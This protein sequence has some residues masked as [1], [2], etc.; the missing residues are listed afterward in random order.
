[1]SNL[2]IDV[3]C[4]KI[5]GACIEVHKTLGPGLFERIYHQCLCRELT[6]RGI[7]YH[8]E[9]HISLNYKG[10]ELDSV[11]RADLLVEDTV[12]VELKAV[13]EWN[14]IFEAQ[15]I[16]YLRLANKPAGLLINFNVPILKDGIKRLFN[17]Q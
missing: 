5:I 15:L 14:H 10:L 6:L 8:D 11:L 17:G 4:G 3:L 9:F 7:A 2:E 1:M 12:I 13:N 16:S